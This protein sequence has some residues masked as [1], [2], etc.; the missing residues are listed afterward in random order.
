VGQACGHQD[1]ATGH[2]HGR[3]HGQSPHLSRIQKRADRYGHLTSPNERRR[4]GVRERLGTLKSPR[5]ILDQARVDCVRE[6][7]RDS[8][9]YARHRRRHLRELLGQDG[10]KNILDHEDKL[11][12]IE[13]IQKFVADYYN[14][15]MIDLKSLNVNT[16]TDV[17]KEHQKT[18]VRHE[19]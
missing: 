17:Q 15:K 6:R 9:R 11:V 18:L 16:T 1:K 13:I 3:R 5:W 14:L 2:H 10:L 19:E 8:G 7:A 4:E 12:T